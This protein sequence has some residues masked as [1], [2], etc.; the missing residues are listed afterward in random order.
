MHHLRN[1]CCYD[2]PMINQ[3]QSKSSS[4]EKA[5]VGI[6]MLETHFPR[7]LGDLGNPASWN[8][9]VQYS[10]VSGASASKALGHESEELLESFIKAGK[11]L[12]A[13]GADGITTSCGFLSLMQN[14][15]S[16]AIDAP[17]AASSLMQVPWVQA[18]LPPGKR[19]GVLTVH[20]QNLSE[21]HLLAAGAAVDTPIAGTENGEEFTRVILNDETSMNIEKCRTDNLRGAEE[22]LTQHEDIGAIVLECTNMVPYAADIQDQTGLPVYSIYTFINWFQSGL[23]AKRFHT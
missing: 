8:F 2:K 9:P 19:V 11:E 13:N 3:Q 18:V 22:L 17:V 5:M 15:L 4:G 10:I 12:V 1:G 16:A 6:L 14:E 7:I 21:E 23:V 20:A